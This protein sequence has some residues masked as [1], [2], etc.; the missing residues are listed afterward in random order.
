MDLGTLIGVLSAFGVGIPIWY[1][2]YDFIVKVSDDKLSELVERYNKTVVAR[3]LGRKHEGSEQIEKLR[4]TLVVPR[5]FDVAWS[6]SDM[7]GRR[8]LLSLCVLAVSSI[9]LASGITVVG[10]LTYF[11]V[12]ILEIVAVIVVIMYASAYYSLLA[13]MRRKVNSMRRAILNEEISEEIS[14]PGRMS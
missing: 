12:A 4:A 13:D 10:S 9:I 7:T 11:L 2:L 3:E 1:K 8:G 5:D 14:A 6:E